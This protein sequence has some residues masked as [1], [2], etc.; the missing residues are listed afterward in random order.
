[1]AESFQ[2]PSIA[3]MIGRD[4]RVFH[5]YITQAPAAL[6]APSTITLHT[7][8]FADL[9]GFAAAPIA[10][11]GRHGQASGRLV[12]VDSLQLQWQRARVRER[13]AGLIPADSL[14][15]GAANLESWLWRRLQTTSHSL[16]EQQQQS[17]DGLRS[18]G[19]R[20]YV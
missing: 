16:V 17:D 14:L 3:V 8:P 10:G 11:V 9:A 4:S 12:L 20:L 1:M 7:A 13:G 6:D 18:T 2:T 19:G 15:F 5:L